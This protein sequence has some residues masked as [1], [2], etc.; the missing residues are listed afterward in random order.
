MINKSTIIPLLIV[1]LLIAGCSTGKGRYERIEGYA[2]GSTF[3]IIYS[4][5]TGAGI[6]SAQV[7]ERVNS[8]LAA[9]DNSLSGYNKGSLLSRFNAGEEIIPDSLFIEVFNRSKE[10][11][12]ESSG[13]FDPSAAPLFDLWGFGF[14]NRDTVTQHLIDSALLLVG[15]DMVSIEGSGD[16]ARVTRE[17]PGVKLNFNAIAQGYTCD[18]IARALDDFGCADYLVEVGREIVCKGLSSRGDKWKVGLDKPL[19]GNFDEGANLQEIIS[20]SDGALVTSGNYRKFYIE[21]GEKRSHTIDPATGRPVKHN[22]LSAT[23]IAS[24]GATADAY[25]TWM[26]VIGEKRA[27]ELASQRNDIEVYLVYGEQDSMKVWHTEGFP[28]YL[29]ESKK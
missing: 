14:S 5:S 26:M 27:M 28:I 18:V 8:L 2:Q 19:D 1:T 11:W 4:R 22:L 7:E 13:A 15:M 16:S 24:D 3:H 9:I 20:M 10:I 23:V 12:L 21:N 17:L 6:K 25:A 29:N